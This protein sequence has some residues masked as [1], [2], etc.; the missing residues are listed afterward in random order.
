MADAISGVE[1]FAK[2]YTTGLPQVIIGLFELQSLAYENKLFALRARIAKLADDLL[3][4]INRTAVEMAGLAD[5]YI[6]ERIHATQS[7]NRPHTG[8]METHIISTPGELGLV[9]VALIDEL[10]KIINPEGQYGS[11][12]RAQEFG[13][14]A[15]AQEWGAIPSQVGRVLF[16]SFDPSGTRPDSAQ[17]GLGAGR[18]A[19]FIPGGNA[20]SGE[21]GF[22]TINVDLPGRHFLEEGSARAGREYVE[23]MDAIKRRYRDELTNVVEATKREL[24]RGRS[25]LFTGHLRA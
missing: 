1:A 3:T 14:G 15:D 17:R 7:R 25:T 6:I 4:D 5:G 21:V 11:F 16:G 18:D 10:D 22:G 13:T 9:N 23:R 2:L 20:N 19:A 24:S 12:W 8:E